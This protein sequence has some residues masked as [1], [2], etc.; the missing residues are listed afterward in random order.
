MSFGEFVIEPLRRKIIIIKEPNHKVK[1]VL[2]SQKRIEII[3][4]IITGARRE[5]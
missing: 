3:I 4:I 5:S 2:L 1:S